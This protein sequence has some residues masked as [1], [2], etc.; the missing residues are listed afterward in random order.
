M[1]SCGGESCVAIVLG[2]HRQTS[3]WAFPNTTKV[4]TIGNVCVTVISFRLYRSLFSVYKAKVVDRDQRPMTR[5]VWGL[6]DQ[7]EESKTAY[8]KRKSVRIH[9]HI[10]FERKLSTI[11]A[12]RV[13]RW[14]EHVDLNTAERCWSA[15][16]K[17]FMRLEGLAPRCSLIA[18]AQMNL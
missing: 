16:I 8:W 10:T 13:V 11:C 5:I 2:Q 9:E 18:A 6:R 4:Q 14:N 17:H 7:P 1:F 3:I 15:R 12:R